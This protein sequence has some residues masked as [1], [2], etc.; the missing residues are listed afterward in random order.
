M[1]II[2]KR[3][4]GNE[5]NTPKFVNAQFYYSNPCV[6]KCLCFE[7]CKEVCFFAH[8]FSAHF[9]SAGSTQNLFSISPSLLY[10]LPDFFLLYSL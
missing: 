10:K 6:A 4:N 8:F 9:F 1:H 3:K 5:K 7:V 2:S